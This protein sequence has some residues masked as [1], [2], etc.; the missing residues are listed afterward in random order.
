MLHRMHIIFVPQ[1]VGWLGGKRIDIHRWGS[2][3]NHHKL[4][5]LCVNN[6]MLTK[7]S[8]LT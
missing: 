5:G 2:K 7:Y 3:I 6:R 8:L 4:H 1:Q